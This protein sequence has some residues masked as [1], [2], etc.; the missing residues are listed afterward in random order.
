MQV[1]IDIPDEA[2]RVLE[3]LALS[4][5]MSVADLVLAEVLR[6]ET[7]DD[8]FEAFSKAAMES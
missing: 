5:N 6:V 3:G 7:A 2:Y 1:V 8:G 4:K